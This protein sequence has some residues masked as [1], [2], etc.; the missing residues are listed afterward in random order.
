MPKE[1]KYC[2]ASLDRPVCAKPVMWKPQPEAYLSLDKEKFGATSREHESED[3]WL[4]LE[5]PTPELQKA[6]ELASEQHTDVLAV[7]VH[8]EER[9]GLFEAGPCFGTGEPP[10][11][12]SFCIP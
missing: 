9:T 7:R 11:K 5:S 6:V 2:W 1:R 10:L 3:F 8:Y 4:D 12:I